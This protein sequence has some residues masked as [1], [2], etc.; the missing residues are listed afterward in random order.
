VPFAPFIEAWAGWLGEPA[1]GD[2]WLKVSGLFVNTDRGA[3]ND[4]R[5]TAAPYT[6]WAGFNYATGLPREDVRQVLRHCAANDIRA[7]S[8]AGTSPDMLDLYEEV[9]REIPLKGRRWVLG[10]IATLSPRDIEK[11]ARMGLVITTH[12]NSN[13]YKSGHL[14]QQRLPPERHGEITPV[15]SLL[16]AGVNVGL[17][18]DNVPVSLFW[19]IWQAVARES[20]VTRQRV[21][22]AGDHACRG[23]ALRDLQRRLSHL[24]RRQ[25]G[26]D[27]A[28]QARGPRRAQRRSARRRGSR[29]P[30]HLGADDHGGRQDRPRNSQ[31]ERLKPRPAANRRRAV[32]VP[33][34][35]AAASGSPRALA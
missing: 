34:L 14:H 15:R 18:T 35:P 7:V 23:A 4:L 9:D 16:D 13:V 25:E 21:A 3:A 29:H 19:P 32:T 6:G 28:R 26:L 10:H 31:L 5:A 2:D 11:I 30:R 12:T 8:L 33:R 24:R 1:L 27:R 20:R 17:V 22:G